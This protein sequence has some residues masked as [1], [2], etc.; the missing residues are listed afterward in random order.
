MVD[1]SMESEFYDFKQAFGGINESL[2]KLTEMLSGMKEFMAKS[3]DE[4]KD[5]DKNKPEDPE[6]KEMAAKIAD[7]EKEEKES[8][9]TEFAESQ[10]NP[11]LTKELSDFS[12]SQIKKLSEMAKGKT[13]S[14]GKTNKGNESGKDSSK[15]L[16]ELEQ[17]EKDF[18]VSGLEISAKEVRAEID[19][20]KGNEDGK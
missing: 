3:G 18:M 16:E 19:Q 4:D 5:K 14:F 20:I 9:A 15:K 17:K 6:K 11:D 2:S 10:G 1:E 8:A 12:V 13:V 7:Y